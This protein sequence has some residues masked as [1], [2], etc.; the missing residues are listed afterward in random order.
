[1]TARGLIV[2]APKSGAG[3]TTVTLALL[4]AFA[5]CGLR[6]QGAKVGPDY[7]DPA[8]HQA[9]TGRASFNLDSWAMRPA[10]LDALALEA[11]AA[12][13]ALIVEGVMGLFD[14][15]GP[16][17]ASGATADIAA[18]LQLP[19]LLVL[20][21]SGQSQSA[22][23]LA[24]G[25]ASHEA[26]VQI[27]GVILNQVGSKR[28]E[29]FV[30]DAMLALDLPVLG[31]IHRDTALAFPERH[32]GLVQ[33]GEH[34]DL[35]SRLSQLADMAERCLDL[36][37]IL[38]LAAPL[39]L[40]ASSPVRALP[41]P[42]MRIALAQDAAFTFVYPHI[43][44]G[45][46]AAGAEIVPFSPLADEAPH[47]TCDSCWLPGGYPEL[48]AGRLAASRRFM[49]GLAAFAQT[50]PVHGECG[51]YMVLGEGIEDA[52]GVHHRMTGLLGH[53]TSFAKRKLHLGYRSATLLGDSAIGR[54]GTTLR[55][56]EFH[57]ASLTETGN[58]APLAEL[59]DGEGNALGIAGGRRGP[60]SG[61]FFH[62]IAEG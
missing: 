4:A 5:R 33:A 16:K 62:V 8:F 38:A 55:G 57:Y 6:V 43:V 23:A 26:N 41:P 19:V 60:V 25:F 18:R 3:K 45:W 51:G 20:D 1:M 36:D 12:S 59:A 32:L 53:A 13:D 11:A 30:R 49:D 48:H 2:S 54:G 34:G 61:T 29:R 56:H 35:P 52:S 14:G 44:A 9:A 21:V 40:A 42:G 17:G 37:A 15:V 50:R 10:L 22:A 24:R 46:R 39:S 31:A 27:A 47:Q 7:I 58:D 28:H